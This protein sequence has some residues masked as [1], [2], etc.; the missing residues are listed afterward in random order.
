MNRVTR[1]IISLVLALIIAA[2]LPLTALAAPAQAPWPVPETFP[3][4][5]GAILMDARS[6]AVLYGQ[7]IHNQ[8]YPASITKILTALLVIENCPNLDDKLTFS[9]RAIYDVE[10]GSSNAGYTEGDT[11]T[12]RT[13]LYALLLASANEA[14]NALAE[15]VSGSIEDFCDLM[16][17]RAKGLGCKDSHFAN[18][19]GLNNE[20]HYTTA[21]DY[22]LICRAAFANDT[23]VQI[24]GTTYYTLP[25]MQRQPDGATIY[26]HH[27]MLRRNSSQY[28]EGIIGGKTGYTTLAGNTLV[29]CAE[30][31]G[32]KLITV[33]LNGHQ[34]HYDDT[35]L[36]LDFG[37]ENFKCI[38]PA[39]YGS[40]YDTVL[41]GLDITGDGVVN[42]DIIKP[43]PSGAVTI[44][45]DSDLEDLNSELVYDIPAA[46]GAPENACAMITYSYGDRT[47]GSQFILCK[48]SRGETD[49]VIGD[50]IENENESEAAK[51]E[52]IT[53]RARDAFLESSLLVKILVIVG[54]VLLA[55]GLIALIIFSSYSLS[56]RGRRKH[57]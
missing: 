22:A 5:E 57:F 49:L 34:T 16:N 51:E 14:A 29:T 7:N 39:E 46:A 10:A 27:N 44:P 1:T 23:F 48:Y 56:R 54:A 42:E 37:F 47:V 38:D 19:S 20:N 41:E 25:P 9:H 26:V 24:N 55:G 32:M 30:R 53:K 11:V 52:P 17:E 8:Y 40:E 6:G 21:Y 12:V 33:V 35:K 3:Q 45:M 18:P 50:P 2:G 36:L 28:Y 31:E 13:A 15:Y 43:S 4:A